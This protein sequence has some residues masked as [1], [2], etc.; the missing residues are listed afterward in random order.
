MTL[1]LTHL[2]I[3]RMHPTVSQARRLVQLADV[4]IDAATKERSSAASAGESW[5]VEDCDLAIAN[6]RAIREQAISGRLRP[7]GGAGLGITRALGEW[8]VST[9][10]FEA[11]DALEAF[12]RDEYGA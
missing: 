4:A 1:P 6:F 2:N 10:L 12:Y 8:G 11:G 9:A 5:L 7:G 3:V